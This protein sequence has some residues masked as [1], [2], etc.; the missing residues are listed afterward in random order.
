MNHSLRIQG[1]AA[2]LAAMLLLASWGAAISAA[3]LRSPFRIT[4]FAFNPDGTAALQWQGADRDIV[5]QFT[6]D[7][8]A[9]LWQ[10]VPGVEWPI[11]GTNWSGAIPLAPG[12]GFLRVV[13]T[14]GVG[15]APIPLK[16]ISLALMAWHDP[17]SDSFFQNCVA[18]HGT[19][20]QEVALDGKT[21]SIHSLMLEFYGQSN[22]RCLTCHYN[23]PNY[24]GP[25]FLTHS[26]GALR[27]QVNYEVNNCTAC[28]AKG[29]FQPLYDR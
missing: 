23:G 15:T 19:R 1:P 5:V 12:K 3:P 9:P 22:D 28:H 27:K 6:A 24:T 17:Q 18:C 16:T 10:P 20:T 14:G 29:G 11:R 4:H 13:T 25:D 7:L 2:A 26:A 21:P 8:T